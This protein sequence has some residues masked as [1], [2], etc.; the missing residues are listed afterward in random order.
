MTKS[1]NLS[2]DLTHTHDLIDAGRDRVSE[3]ITFVAEL[4]LKGS[5]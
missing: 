5:F 1:V 2:R 3:L 4:N